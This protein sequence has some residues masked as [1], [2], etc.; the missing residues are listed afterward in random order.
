MSTRQAGFTLIEVLIALAVLA[1]ALVAF[2]STGAQ[3]AD[4]ATYI[5]QRTVAEWVARNQLVA[6]QLA[7]NWP[8]TGS[9]DGN[10][11][12]GGSR[13]HWEAEV[14]SSPD[15]NVRRVNVRVYAKDPDRQQP[16]NDSIVLMSGFLSQH[17][18][19]RDNP[20]GADDTNDSNSDDEDDS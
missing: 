19:P 14:K 11:Q 15:P 7:P 2:V 12:M 8:D 6:Y 13:W 20:N 9:H 5:R 1:I 16:S 17:E 3:N 4:Y 18:Q 10:T